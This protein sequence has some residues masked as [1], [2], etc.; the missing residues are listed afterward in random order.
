LFSPL[1]DADGGFEDQEGVVSI[2]LDPGDSRRDQRGVG[3]RLVDGLSKFLHPFFEFLIHVVLRLES[4]FC[5]IIIP[6]AGISS[7]TFRGSSLP[8]PHI[9]RT[10]PRFRNRTHT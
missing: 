6:E 10:S 2:L 8:L 9:M 3:K 4:G 5:V 1:A 7:E